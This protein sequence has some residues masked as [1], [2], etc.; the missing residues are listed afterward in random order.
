MPVSSLSLVLGSRHELDPRLPASTLSTVDQQRQQRQQQQQQQQQPAIVPAS[1]HTS[2]AS[3]LAESLEDELESREKEARPTCIRF[4]L[5]SQLAIEWDL[6]AKGACVIGRANGCSVPL[7]AVPTV[8]GRHARIELDPATG[9]VSV[10][11]LGSSN[12]TYVDSVRL[13]KNETV[14]IGPKSLVL[15]AGAAPGRGVVVVRLSCHQSCDA[16]SASTSVGSARYE[17]RRQLGA[18]AFA[19]V[20][21]ARRQS[22][23]AAVAVKAASRTKF[24]D[25]TM[26]L[27]VRTGLPPPDIEL[28]H[29]LLAA[30]DCPHIVNVLDAYSDGDAFCVVLELAPLGSLA[31]VVKGYS[32]KRL[33]LADTAV[34]VGQMVEALR[35]LRTKRII[36][37]DVKATNML[38]FACSPHWRIKLADFGMAVKL[39][40]SADLLMTMCGT[41][42]YAA[43]EMLALRRIPSN[44]SQAASPAAPVLSRRR[45]SS[46]DYL[47]GYSFPVDMWSLG[48]T[49]YW[50]LAG[51]VPFAGA[52]RLMFSQ[53]ATGNY[54]FSGP[55]WPL[56]RTAV[57]QAFVASLLEVDVLKRLTPRLALR[58]PFLRRPRPPTHPTCAPPQPLSSFSDLA[59]AVLSY[60]LS[61]LPPADVLRVASVSKATARV[62]GSSDALWR[63]LL[64][65][66]WADARTYW[67]G[68]LL[69]PAPPELPCAATSRRAV[70]SLLRLRASFNSLLAAASGTMIDAE[71]LARVVTGGL[72]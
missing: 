48:V 47:R 66:A 16:R 51:D 12:G 30:L 21:E 65:V 41:P 1:S 23:G 29:T 63:V 33:P 8:S 2:V 20:Y 60:L 25:A 57:A 58:H 4:L 52:K 72:R 9:V 7:A 27:A 71:S 49:T 28:E 5:S 43:P 70:M 22:D 55:A 68:G 19:V 46:S 59:D 35:Y 62:V 61:F 36:H 37:R 42:A 45:G 34:V 44:S 67:A 13:A 18:G 24:N 38:V 32:D 15:L 39:G 3:S 31:A 14:V 10:T 69:P 53:I 64:R 11:D 56:P 26:A 40:S 6:E 54:S 17:L 50:C